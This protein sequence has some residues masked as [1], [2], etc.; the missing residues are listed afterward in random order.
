MTFKVYLSPADPRTVKLS[1]KNR[2]RK[3]FPAMLVTNVSAPKSRRKLTTTEHANGTP[4]T[5]LSFPVRRH[6]HPN[7]GAK[8]SHQEQ[9]PS[10]LAV[11]GDVIVEL[12]VHEMCVPHQ[13]HP[14]H[15]HEVGVLGSAV[16]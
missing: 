5:R 4:L 14:V 11:A 8:D 9:F 3:A 15:H 2:M 12:F 7:G 16:Q 13:D 10:D 6:K 1:V